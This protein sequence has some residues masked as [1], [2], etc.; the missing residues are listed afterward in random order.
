MN[1]TLTTSTVTPSHSAREII[2][3]SKLRPQ[4][5]LH[6]RTGR[7]WSDL[8][9]YQRPLPLSASLPGT[10]N[11]PNRQEPSSWHEGLPSL[12]A[13]V[14]QRLYPSRQD[15]RRLGRRRRDFKVPSAWQSAAGIGRVAC[16]LA[17]GHGRFLPQP[18]GTS[19]PR[20]AAPL[21]PRS[22]RPARSLRS[23][24]RWTRPSRCGRCNRH[25]RA[26]LG[27][28]SRTAGRGE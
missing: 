25:P 26:T 20:R 14:H 15:P 10:G 2:P 16:L 18:A 21:T 1:C 22:R 23:R 9:R 5:G 7:V 24:S 4:S 17:R 8:P 28:G 27:T 13:Q 11:V 3:N 6:W 12:S 19:R